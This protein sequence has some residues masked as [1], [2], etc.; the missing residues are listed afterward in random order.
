MD[1]FVPPQNFDVIIFNESVYYSKD[2]VG[3]IKRYMNFLNTDGIIAT[4]IYG[5]KLGND[6][7]RLIEREFRRLKYKTTTN[8]RGTWHCHIIQ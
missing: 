6:L 4:S 5:N 8:Q 3:S 7:V 2:P 1:N